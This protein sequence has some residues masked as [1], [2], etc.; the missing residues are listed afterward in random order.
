MKTANALY[1]EWMKKYGSCIGNHEREVVKDI[2]TFVALKLNEMLNNL[3]K[4]MRFARNEA[5]EEAAKI[6]EGWACKHQCEK[7]LSKGIRA[8]IDKEPK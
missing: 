5:L 8:I 3:P 2:D 4:N 1:H 6:V 7:Q